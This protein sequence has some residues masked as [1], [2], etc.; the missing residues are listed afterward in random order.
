MIAPYPVTPNVMNRASDQSMRRFWFQS[1]SLPF[2]ALTLFQLSA[3]EY[4][5]FETVQAVCV[6]LRATSG[7]PGLIFERTSEVPL[8]T[9]V[10]ANVARRWLRP[11]LFSDSTHKVRPRH[12]SY[13]DIASIRSPQSESPGASAF[14]GRGPI[15]YSR[16][17][18]P[19]SKN[20]RQ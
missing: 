4:R 20:R 6:A 19:P 11:I 8:G 16:C 7:R 9:R 18:L 1:R 13:R 12:L 2:S 14:F 3:L 15:G 5:P 10:L 17:T